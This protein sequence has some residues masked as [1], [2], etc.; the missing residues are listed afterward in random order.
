MTSVHIVRVMKLAFFFSY[1]EAGGASGACDCQRS[2]VGK[3]GGAGQR[4]GGATAPFLSGLEG[5]ESPS[6]ISDMLCE[7]RRARPLLA[8]RAACWNFTS[9]RGRVIAATGGGA[10]RSGTGRLEERCAAGERCCEETVIAAA[11]RGIFAVGGELGSMLARHSLFTTDQQ[12]APDVTAP[13]AKR[14]DLAC[15]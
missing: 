6:L 10:G 9:L 15:M 5:C 4:T 14:Q 13:T 11:A 8:L 2:V 7:S 12:R 3:R 1:S